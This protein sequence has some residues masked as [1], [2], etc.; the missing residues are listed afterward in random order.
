MR[1]RPDWNLIGA[2]TLAALASL[3]LYA[4][5]T[6]PTTTDIDPPQP[7]ENDVP[8]AGDEAL[9]AEVP[10][11]AVGVETNMESRFGELDVDANGGLSE[12]EVRSDVALRQ[13]FEKLDANDDGLLNGNEFALR[14]D[15]R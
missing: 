11:A 3:A 10:R 5:V 1:K 2:T 8:G 9:P 15:E 4:Q 13:N 7:I 12:D 14:S 6:P